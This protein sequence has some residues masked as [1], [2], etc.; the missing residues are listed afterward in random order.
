MLRALYRAANARAYPFR[1]KTGFFSRA[2]LIDGSAALFERPSDR[3][4][5][6]K[7]PSLNPRKIH[8]TRL[9]QTD[10]SVLTG[11]VVYLT[12]AKS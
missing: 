12:T 7:I 2:E 6:S 4:P 3:G 8:V 9:G 10:R 1:S 5:H 11:P